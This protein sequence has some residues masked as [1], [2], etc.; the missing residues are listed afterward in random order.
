MSYSKSINYQEAKSDIK[1]LAALIKSND[2]LIVSNRVMINL[3]DYYSEYQMSGKLI[4]SSDFESVSCP[5]NLLLVSNWYTE[6]H[7]NTDLEELIAR[8]KINPDQLN[9]DV[10]LS[11]ELNSTEVYR[12]IKPIE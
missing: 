3:I 1:G 11:K 5:D 10:L 8:L 7:S 12:I 6:Y 9:K 2:I 4:E